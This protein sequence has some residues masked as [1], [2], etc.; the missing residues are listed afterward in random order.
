M[1]GWWWVSQKSSAK[2]GHGHTEECVKE[3]NDEDKVK[4][5][6]EVGRGQSVPVDETEVKGRMHGAM[7]CCAH[8]KYVPRVC[9]YC[10]GKMS[11]LSVCVTG[12]KYVPGLGNLVR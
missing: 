7:H 4:V 9:P 8:Y 11:P 3:E 1:I 5:S 2:E 12:K 6:K 10:L